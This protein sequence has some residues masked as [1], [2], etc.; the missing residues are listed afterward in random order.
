MHKLVQLRFSKGHER[1]V[2]LEICVRTDV[3]CAITSW[4]FSLPF[5]EFESRSEFQE[6]ASFSSIVQTLQKNR[7]D[8]NFVL[9]PNETYYV[10]TKE[11]IRLGKR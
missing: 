9:Y 2:S 6:C 5:R 3:F 4:D 7:E 10:T 1:A 8:F 11:E